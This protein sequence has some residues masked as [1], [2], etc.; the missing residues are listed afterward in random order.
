[1]EKQGGYWVSAVVIG[2][3][4]IIAIILAVLMA[5]INISKWP[6]GV[7]ASFFWQS[8]EVAELKDKLQLSFDALKKRLEGLRKKLAEAIEEY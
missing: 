2:M 7:R 4:L 8:E 5:Y 6:G 1:M 3:P